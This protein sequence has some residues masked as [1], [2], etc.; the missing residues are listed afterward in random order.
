MVKPYELSYPIATVNW[1]RTY[2]R[3]VPDESF[4]PQML[5]IRDAGCRKLMISGYVTVE[6]ADFDM[7]EETKRIGGLLDSYGFQPAQHHGL[8]ALYA[9]LE[10][11]QEPVVERLLQAVSYTANLNAPVLVIHPDM[12][13]HPE[14]WK[15][16]VPMQEMYR[17]VTQ[18]YGEDALLETAAKNL[19]EAALEAGRRGIRIALENTVNC[20]ASGN[21]WE[22]MGTF[23]FLKRLVAA[24]DSPAVGFCLDSGHAHCGTS[25]PVPDWIRQ[26]G[27][28]LFTTHFHDNRGNWTKD[29]HMPP[30][31]GTIPWIDVIWALWDMG[32]EDTV[33]FESGPWPVED[34]YRHAAAY[35][36]AMEHMAQ[37]KR[38]ENEA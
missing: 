38:D 11:P 2:V 35:W 32:Y 24:A 33:N 22:A 14:S 27:D 12:Y 34:G 37:Q 25:L 16:N 18:E 13:Y 28:K 29:E 26:M 20:D 6:E 30:G 9:P 5:Q 36:R 21:Q 4:V 23:R 15:Q 31:F 7:E 10:D 8:S 1:D 3:R 19:H 17:R